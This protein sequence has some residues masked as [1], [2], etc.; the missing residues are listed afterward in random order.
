MVSSK[1]EEKNG[2]YYRVPFCETSSC[3][4]L[5]C[6]F[7]RAQNKQKSKPALGRLMVKKK[8]LIENLAST[9]DSESLCRQGVYPEEVSRQTFCLI[10]Y[11]GHLSLTI[12]WNEM[13]F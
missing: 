2:S 5:L 11:P 13:D 10:F 6:L 1:E 7:Y 8:N 12:F 4:R 9:S 3:H